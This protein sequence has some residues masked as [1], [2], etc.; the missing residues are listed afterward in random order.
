MFSRGILALFYIG[1]LL[2]GALPVAAE[3]APPLKVVAFGTSLTSRGGWPE[4]VGGELAA[5]IARPVDVVTVALAGSTTEWALGQVR[6][7]IDEKPD[8]ILI[9]FYGNDSAMNRWMSLSTSRANFAT[10]LDSLRGGAPEARVVM[11]AFNPV[12]GIRGWVRP[13]FSS[14]IDA[15]REAIVERGMDYIDLRPIWQALSPAD[16]DGAIPDGLHPRPEISARL[17]APPLARFLAG[18]RCASGG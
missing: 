17:V 15:H 10:I 2:A 14:Y 16:L 9:E 11:M 18:G 6:R 13:F 3:A 1:P 7:V 5:C 8:I 4:A 12:W